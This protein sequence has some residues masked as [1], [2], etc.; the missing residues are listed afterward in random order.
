METGDGLLARVHP[1][2]G[3]LTASQ[4]RLIAGAAGTHGNGHLDVT[5]RGNLQIR[6]LGDG[7]YPALLERLDQAGLAEPEGDGPLRLTAVSPLAGIDPNDRIDALALAG[8][9]EGR[10]DALG[11]LPAKVFV[12]VDGGGSVPLDGIGAD[13]HLLATGEDEIACGLASPAGPVWIGATSLAQA[14]MAAASILAGFAAM[15][16]S[17]RTGARRI[18]DLAPGLSHELATLVSLA[19]AASP[20][21]AGP[22][23]APVRSI[24]G[25][26]TPS[27]WRCPSAAATP[28][29][30]PAPQPGASVSATVK[31]VSPSPAACCCRASRRRM[32]RR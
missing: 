21:V 25:T 3:V 28:P 15:R 26:I 14:P 11:D 10:L 27:F 16:R 22:P 20:P 12:A 1:P 30:S 6:G 13:L 23:S 2:G 24:L 7:T 4:A 9:V 19:P 17:E 8:A 31:F 32:A 29:G 18:R 5:A